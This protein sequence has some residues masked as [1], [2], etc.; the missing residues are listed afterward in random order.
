M[1]GAS[2]VSAPLPGEYITEEGWGHLTIS[3]SGDGA[4]FSIEAIGANG[5]ACML[6]GKIVG[7]ES[8]LPADDQSEACVVYFSVDS[9]GIEV[10]SNGVESCRQ[11]CGQRARFEGMYFK[12]AEGCGDTA[13]RSTRNKFKHLYDTKSY[14]SALATLAP[15]LKDCS[16]TLDWIEF[17]R[18]SNDA[19]ITQYKLALFDDC[20]RTLEPYATD[21][22]R[23][24]EQILSDYPPADGENYIAVVKAART[25]LR[26]CR[27]R[28]AG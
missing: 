28:R 10:N 14:A 11:F 20:L 5:H 18:I 15:L 27:R 4:A 13:R 1:C 21:A 6:D 8:K 3:G 9:Q 16:R 12:P 26:L 2:A 24:D 25:N 22:A 17:G 19:A 7:G 23:T